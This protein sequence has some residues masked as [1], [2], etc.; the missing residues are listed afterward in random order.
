MYNMAKILADTEIRKKLQKI[1]EVRRETVCQALNC[2][3]NTELSKKIRSTAIKLGA[4][5][6]REET[7]IFK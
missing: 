6:K 3:T 5:V 4:S 7:V 1:F 2:R